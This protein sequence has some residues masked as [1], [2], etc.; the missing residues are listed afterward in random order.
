MSAPRA[1]NLALKFLL[2]LAAFAA[3]V[4]WGAGVGSGVVSVLV[5]AVAGIAVIG[6]WARFAAPRSERRLPARSRI[7]FE[8][9]VFALACA[10]LA[11]TGHGTLAVIFAVLVLL[12]AALLGAFGDWEA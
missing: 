9:G 8:L 5:A 1:V 7:A 3:V 6:L 12:N 2:E 10:A 4:V 11:A